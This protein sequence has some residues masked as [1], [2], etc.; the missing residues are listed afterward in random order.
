MSRVVLPVSFVF[1]T[2][3]IACGGAQA[4]EEKTPAAAPASTVASHMTDH[5]TRVHDIEEAVIRGDLE[6]VGEPARWLQSH[7]T[8]EGL[9]AG[10]EPFISEMRNAASAVASTDDAGNAAVATATMLAAC[11]KCHTATGATPKM[12]EMPPP[13]AAEGAVGHMREHQYAVDLMAEGLERPS[14]DLWKQG[15]RALAAAPLAGADLPEVPK[16]VDEMETRVHELADRALNASDT[17]ART[18]IYGEI[19]GDCASCH[20]LHGKV[21]GPGVGKQVG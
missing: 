4:P 17:G 9:P 16:S 3:T 6:A 5:F 20:G 19:V 15:A 14:D 11:G 18:A 13:A 12:P 2:F 21:W 1:L 8:M 10:S 7:M